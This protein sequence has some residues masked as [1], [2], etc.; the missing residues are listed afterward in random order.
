[1]NVKLLIRTVIFLAI[2][3][4]VLYVGINNLQPI[5]FSFPI[6]SDQSV[7]KPAWEIYFAIFAVG[8]FGGVVLAA[9]GGRRSGSKDK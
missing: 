1:M 2:L 9:G 5:K 6:A 3:F 8:V 7:E 4:V